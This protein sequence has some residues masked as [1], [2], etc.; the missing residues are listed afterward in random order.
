MDELVRVRRRRRITEVRAE[1]S[2]IRG[3]IAVVRLIDAV[4]FQQIDVD[5]ARRDLAC[6]RSTVG[7]RRIERPRRAAAAAIVEFIVCER[8]AVRRVARLE[9][10]RKNPRTVGV[11]GS[12]DVLRIRSRGGR[13]LVVRLFV[14]GTDGEDQLI[15]VLRDDVRIRARRGVWCLHLALRT[16]DDEVV[17]AVVG[18]V[19][20][21]DLEV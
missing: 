12:I 5:R 1:G 9:G 16:I 4:L 17:R 15:L 18:L 3:G 14:G 19:A 13:V 2:R 21:R 10:I 6:A 11:R 8:L 20:A 7:I